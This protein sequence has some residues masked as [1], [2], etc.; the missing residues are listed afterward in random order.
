MSHPK[1][2]KAVVNPK[3]T[4]FYL[5]KNVIGA[6][7]TTFDG[8]FFGDVLTAVAQKVDE[9]VKDVRN[10]LHCGDVENRQRV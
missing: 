10:V 9:G 8:S 2:F 3:T 4:K 7:G 1:P 5:S 6:G